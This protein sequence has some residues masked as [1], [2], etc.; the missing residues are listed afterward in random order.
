MKRLSNEDR[1]FIFEQ[2]EAGASVSHIAKALDRSYQVIRNAV[3]SKWFAEMKSE[4]GS[5]EATVVEEATEVTEAT[6]AT[7][8]TEETVTEEQPD[9][10]YLE[11]VEVD[12]SEVEETAE[13]DP[14][15][16]SGTGFVVDENEEDIPEGQFVEPEP[17]DDNLPF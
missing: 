2:T 13:E 7:E 15:D 17:T 6:E 12:N 4:T 1:L 3:H 16:Y 10:E 8:V 9:T 14:D 5:E 11:T